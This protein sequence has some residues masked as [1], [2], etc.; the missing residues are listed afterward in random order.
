M[1]ALRAAFRL[2][3][4][5]FKW[6]IARQYNPLAVSCSNERA[7]VTSIG[8]AEI[9]VYLRFRIPVSVRQRSVW[10]LERVEGVVTADAQPDGRRLGRADGARVLLSAAGHRYLGAHVRAV[11]AGGGIIQLERTAEMPAA[12]TAQ[13]EPLV[14]NARGACVAWNDTGRVADGE[15]DRLVGQGGGQVAY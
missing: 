6:H 13:G 4:Q 11:L 5:H 12:A 1:L 7:I 10:T 3:T 8:R 9:D 14:T 15:G 2:L